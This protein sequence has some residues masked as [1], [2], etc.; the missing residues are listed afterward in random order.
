MEEEC[1]VIE[2]SFS[3]VYFS[4]FLHPLYLLWIIAFSLKPL[5]EG[6]FSVWLCVLP[7]VFLIL[8]ADF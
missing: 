4:P 7:L 2:T 5:G 1:C 8:Y 3:N 6:G